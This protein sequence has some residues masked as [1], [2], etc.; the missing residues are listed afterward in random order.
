MRHV[1]QMDKGYGYTNKSPVCSS[2]RKYSTYILPCHAILSHA[3]PH[4]REE[5]RRIVKEASPISSPIQ[6]LYTHNYISMYL[7]AEDIPKLRIV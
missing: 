2:R 7:Y 3:M 1:V 4:K 5:A 6:D